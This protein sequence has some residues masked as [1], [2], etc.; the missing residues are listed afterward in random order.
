MLTEHAKKILRKVK[1]RVLKE[2]GRLDMREWAI[3]KSDFRPPCNT[4]GCIAGNV[5]VAEMLDQGV[6]FKRGE[7]MLDRYLEQ[8]YE[9][10]GMAARRVLELD[11][12]QYNR[13]FFVGFWPAKF[14]AAK[15]PWG[16]WDLVLPMDRAVAWPVKGRL[17][18][19]G[20]PYAQVVANRIQHFIDTD[21]DE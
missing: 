14:R 8:N 6:K 11:E 16:D 17:K 3:S 7:D 1:T 10:I 21:G 2:P 5:L 13:L 15:D 19:Q 18:P 12:D 9:G 20:K 4:V